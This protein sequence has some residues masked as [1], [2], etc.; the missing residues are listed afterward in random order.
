MARTTQGRRRGYNRMRVIVLSALQRSNRPTPAA[1]GDA[2]SNYVRVTTVDRT[3]NFAFTPIVAAFSGSTNA[4]AVAGLSSAICG[5]VPFFICNPSSLPVISTSIWLPAA[6]PRG[7]AW[8][9][10]GRRFVGAR[11]LGFLDQIGN[12]ANGV[13]AALASNG[14]FGDCQPTAQVMTKA[15]ELHRRCQGFTEHA[16]RLQLA[17]ARLASEPPCS[18]STNVAKDVVRGS[19]CGWSQNAA[20]AATM[21]TNNPPRYF[22]D[23]PIADLPTTVF[24]KSWGIPATV[25]ITSIQVRPTHPIHSVQAEGLATARGTGAPISGQIIR[26]ITWATSRALEAE[27]RIDRHPLRNLFVGSRGSGEPASDCKAGQ[28]G[29]QRLSDSPGWRCLAPAL[30]PIRRVSIGGGS[31]PLS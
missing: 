16:V 5:V 12:G 8:C 18:P 26:G 15:R 25:A 28:G 27:W 22:P 23:S 11:E 3:A 31:P 24:P 9:S 20:T 1:T 2:N 7:Q 4:S 6:R 29:E 19:T 17:T 13:A 14:L 21:A 10:T 30:R